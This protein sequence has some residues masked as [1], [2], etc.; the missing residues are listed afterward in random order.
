MSRWVKCATVDDDEVYVNLDFVTHIRPSRDGS[1]IC[2]TDG[3]DRFL[4]VAESPSQVL[5]K[6]E[7]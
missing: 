2:F 4:N 5:A 3:E 7:V 6:P 1:K